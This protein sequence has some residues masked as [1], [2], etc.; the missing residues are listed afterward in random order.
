MPSILQF[1]FVLLESVEEGNYKELCNLSGV[2]GIEELAIQMLKAIFV[3]HDMARNEVS[4]TIYLLSHIKN[5]NPI[6]SCRVGRE[7]QENDCT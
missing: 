5:V 3:A 2:L 6:C 1:A 7:K 4:G